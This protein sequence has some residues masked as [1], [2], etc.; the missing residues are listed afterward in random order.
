MLIIIII[1]DNLVPDV[2]FQK[3]EGKGI[4]VVLLTK[5]AT[6]HPA[7]A[8]TFLIIWEFSLQDDSDEVNYWMLSLHQ[9]MDI[10]CSYVQN[11]CL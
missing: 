11:L 1:V 5:L 8:G 9:T 6:K 10:L 2:L 7:V 4:Q 3:K